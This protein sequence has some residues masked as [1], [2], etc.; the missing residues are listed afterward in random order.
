MQ[1]ANLKIID[2]LLSESRSISTSKTI[3]P[4]V[5]PDFDSFR[6]VLFRESE[7][8]PAPVD[9]AIVGGFVADC[10]AFAFAAGYCY[11]L[12]QLVPALGEN[13]ITCFCI[14]EEGGGHP[15]AIKSKLVPS[16]NEMNPGNTFTLNGK[17][18][19][20]TCAKEADQFLVAASDGIR[21]DGTNSIRM[22]TIDSK[23]PGVRIVP[24]ENLHLVPEISHC[25]LIFTDVH[26]VAT[27]LLAGD[28]YTDYIKPF[29]TIEDLHIS[30]GILGYL[31][32]NACRYDWGRDIKE[33]I[34]GR[35]VSVRNL[36]LS[37]PGAPAVHIVTGDVLK[38]IKELFKLLEPLW[39]KAGGKARQDW[40]R[41]KILMTI[42]D[43]ART[44]RLETAWE[45]YE[46]RRLS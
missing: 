2:W 26:I 38:Q 40:D 27:D 1:N 36:A 39:E 18:K 37:N 19:Y 21:D 9:K 23:A 3:A 8:W 10:T 34:L 20:V 30:A 43:K 46:K 14:T 41:D 16:A 22:M 44:R 5:Y 24:M 15:R 6:K 28:G 13:A 7:S 12:Q 25:E 33:S 17:K 45:F 31:F 35:I 11:A 4:K 42:A 32:R 29:R